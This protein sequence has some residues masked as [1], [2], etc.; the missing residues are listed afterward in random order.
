MGKMA[1]FGKILECFSLSSPTGSCSCFCMSSTD[2]QSEVL[3]QGIESKP[4]IPSDNKQMTRLKDLIGGTH[5]TLAFQ[6]KPKVVTLRVAIHCHGCAR[7]VEKHISKMDGVTSYKI[8][9][10]NKMVVVIGDIIPF[11]VLES[12]SKVKYAELWSA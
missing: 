5:Q 2:D 4:L 7:R 8:D 6:L 12:V 11:E 10:D 9:L 1:S 3:G